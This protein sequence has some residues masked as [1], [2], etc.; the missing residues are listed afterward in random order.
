[1]RT[2]LF[3]GHLPATKGNTWMSKVIDISSNSYLVKV[4]YFLFIFFGDEQEQ[5][6][7]LFSPPSPTHTP[8]PPRLLPKIFFWENNSRNNKPPLSESAF[9]SDHRCWSRQIQSFLIASAQ[10]K[11]FHLKK[12]VD[13][14]LKCS[15]K[16]TSTSHRIMMNLV[17]I[18]MK[19]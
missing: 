9:C 18:L 2:Y 4:K 1:M 14:H 7:G 15:I 13:C 16:N 8:L 6:R 12:K 11:Y 3:F 19:N 10:P 17:I 5:K